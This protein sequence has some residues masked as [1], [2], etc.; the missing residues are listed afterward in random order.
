MGLDNTLII[1]ELIPDNSIEPSN[2]I[3]K[4]SNYQEFEVWERND[5][6]MGITRCALQSG[7][8]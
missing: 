3:K 7:L 2:D 4:A 5:W 1:M 6:R 8:F